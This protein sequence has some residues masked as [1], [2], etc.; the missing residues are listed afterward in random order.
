MSVKGFCIVL[1]ETKTDTDLQSEWIEYNDGIVQLVMND[2][3]EKVRR[4]FGTD[5][6]ESIH[7]LS[8]TDSA[9][10]ITHLDIENA[11]AHEIEKVIKDKLCDSKNTIS[12]N[13]EKLC[14]ELNLKIE[15]FSWNG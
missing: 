9:K 12:G 5:S 8:F 10:L 4:A 6:Y 7:R 3:G 2:S 15:F 1:K 14:K 11:P 13:F